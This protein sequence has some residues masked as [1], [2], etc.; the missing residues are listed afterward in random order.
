M[1]QYRIWAE[2]IHGGVHESRNEPP[3][4]S[5]FCRAGGTSTTSKKSSDSM[6]AAISQ[7]ASALSPKSAAGST[8]TSVTTGSIIDNRSKCY[9]QLSELK[10]LYETG[11]MS[12][13]EYTMEREA[14]MNTLKGLSGAASVQ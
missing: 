6:S 4:T 5:M 7:L 8:C 1:M 12:E 9:K 13:A 10:H 2:S 3:A 14:V 11:L